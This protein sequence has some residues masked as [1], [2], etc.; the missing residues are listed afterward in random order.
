MMVGDCS[1]DPCRQGVLFNVTVDEIGVATVGNGNSVG[2][3][4]G[5]IDAQ[6]SGDN[7]DSTLKGLDGSS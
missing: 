1:T 2:D 3:K 6:D 5:V 7:L 4:D